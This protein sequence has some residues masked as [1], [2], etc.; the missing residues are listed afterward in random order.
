MKPLSLYIHI[1]F[2]KKKCLYCDFPSFTNCE[3]EYEGYIK[4]LLNEISEKSYELKDYKI[5]TIFIGGGTPT[6][7]PSSYI[8]KI[9]DLIV[10]KFDVSKEAEIT[11][12]ANPGTV[13]K[14]S[15]NELSNMYINRISMGVQAWQNK[16]LENLG[17]IYKINDFIKNYFEVREAGFNNV[18]LDLMFALP[19]QT[20]DDWQETLENIIK[21]SPE[22]ISAYSLIL[23]EGTPFY[24]MYKPIDDEL[25]RNMYYLAKEM[26]NDYGYNQYEISNFSK[27]GYESKH[28]IVYWKTEE[29]IGLG[30][31]SHSYIDNVRFHNTYDMKKYICQNGIEIIED[32]E[33]LLVEDRMSEFM[34][35][36][37]RMNSG[38]KNN[39]FVERFGHNIKDIYNEEIGYLLEK[40]LIIEKEDGISLTNRGI[41]VSNFVFEKFLKN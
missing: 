26:L 16:H 18:N 12:E 41:D 2:C 25:D 15:L 19:N 23:E 1:P 11:I 34:F 8:G 27:F 33:K 39:I 13:D 6:V 32:I 31:G 7:L 40:K 35:M 36:G 10:T 5:N 28:N 38:V 22:H 14:K 9:I 20:L 3:S 24:N 17:R 37:L 30:L 29:Y 21:L 4:A